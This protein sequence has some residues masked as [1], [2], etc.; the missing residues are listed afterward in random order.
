MLSAMFAARPIAVVPTSRRSRFIEMAAA[1]RDPG[2]E[3]EDRAARE[4]LQRRHRRFVGRAVEQQQHRARQDQPA[5]PTRIA[6]AADPKSERRNIE[7]QA[8]PIV[9]EESAKIAASARWQSA[10]GAY[11]SPSYTRYDAAYQPVS[12]SVAHDAEYNG[13]DVGVERER[14]QEEAERQ[15]RRLQLAPHRAVVGRHDRSGDAL[16]RSA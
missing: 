15:R 12:A 14:D 8:G 2:A 13:V 9:D 16:A 6:I 11:V 4:D 5:P 7:P 1:C 10:D 3:D